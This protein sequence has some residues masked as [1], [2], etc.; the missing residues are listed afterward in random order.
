M[1]FNSPVRIAFY[2]S[3]CLAH[4]IR[5][6][7]RPASTNQA[8]I[9]HRQGGEGVTSHSFKDEEDPLGD[10]SKKIF[11]DL[12][13]PEKCPFKLKRDNRLNEFVS[14]ISRIHLFSLLKWEMETRERVELN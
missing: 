2:R 14:Q 5:H 3:R 11:S 4:R 12:L 9:S 10:T 6:A 1:H 7:I 8:G 13:N